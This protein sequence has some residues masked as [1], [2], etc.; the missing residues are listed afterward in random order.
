MVV[1]STLLALLVGSAFAVLVAAISDQRSE[2]GL[3]TRSQETLSLTN[4][5]ERLVLDLESGQRGF[6]V[7]GDAR[8]LEPWQAARREI[9]KAGND[10]V[11]IAGDGRGQPERA[12]Q[13][14]DAIRSYVRDYS[15]PL[16]R[17]AQR[18]DP[19]ARSDAA[20]RDGKRRVDAIRARFDRFVGAER[21]I[22]ARRNDQSQEAS[23]RAIIAA[24]GGLIGSVILIG[25]FGVFLLRA[26]VLPIRRAAAMAGR[27]AEGDLSARMPDTG[28]GEIGA[29]E[30]AFNT[31]GRSLEANRNELAA[32][33]ARVVAT[34][35]ETRRRLQRDLHDGAQQRLVHT[36]ITLKLA[37]RELGDAAAPAAKLVDEALEHAE[38]ATAELRDLSHGILPASLNRGLRAGIEALVARIRIPVTVDVTDQRL[39]QTLEANA[40]FI[41]AEALTNTVKYADATSARV[42]AVVDGGVLQLEVR[43]DGIGGARIDDSSGLLGLRDRAAALNGELHVE[44]P[45]GGGTRIA[46]TLPI[47]EP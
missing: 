42:T 28:V 32:S 46:A 35:D 33:R 38:R 9:P 44:S 6:L 8:F 7:T 45:P 47:P 22:F 29:L 23:K 3:A 16:V 25:L 34:A 40:Y 17:A 24:A 15:E 26:I 1:A 43:D 14:V 5:L 21:D 10:L 36:V 2:A 4:R 12:R 39:P 19:S 18:G 27:M 41:A 13:I 30:H 20:L 31:M 11:S 37:R